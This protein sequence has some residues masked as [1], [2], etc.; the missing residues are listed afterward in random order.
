MDGSYFLTKKEYLH[1]K[2]IMI[3]ACFALP[4][5]FYYDGDIDIITAVI[6]HIFICSYL[7]FSY[8]RIKEIYIENGNLI[9]IGKKGEITTPITNIRNIHEVGLF[10]SGTPALTRVSV[11][12]AI[13]ELKT[14][15]IYGKKIYCCVKG[16]NKSSNPIGD[17]MKYINE[18][19]RKVKE[20]TN[21]Q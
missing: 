19:Q 17:V 20:E 10:S 18:E 1:H 11:Y 9:I 21:K 13:I 15:S 6:I 16:L 4:L 3:C 12:D 14:N 7:L 2:L 8:S 5:L